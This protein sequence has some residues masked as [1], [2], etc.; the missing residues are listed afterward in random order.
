MVRALTKGGFVAWHWRSTVTE[1]GR[2]DAQIEPLM[3]FNETEAKE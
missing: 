1:S 3:N 2:L